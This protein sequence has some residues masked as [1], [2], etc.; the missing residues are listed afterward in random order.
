MFLILDIFYVLYEWVY[1]FV[2]DLFFFFDIFGS[3]FEIS[4]LYNCF[5]LGFVFFV[6]E[7]GIGFGVVLVFVN[8]YLSIIFG[9]RV[10]LIVGVDMNVFVCCVMLGMVKKV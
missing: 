6:V 5:G 2:E 7:V 9:F 4:F 1:E 8:V 3:V 10:V